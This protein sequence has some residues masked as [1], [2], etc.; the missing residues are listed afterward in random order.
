MSSGCLSSSESIGLIPLARDRSRRDFSEFYELF[1][2]MID[3]WK[4]R[5]NYLVGRDSVCEDENTEVRG[6]PAASVREQSLHRTRV[7]KVTKKSAGAS[8]KD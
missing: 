2:Q 5:L 3:S 7:A 1:G 6:I 8:F 4:K